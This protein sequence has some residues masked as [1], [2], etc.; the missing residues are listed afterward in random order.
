MEQPWDGI[1][2]WAE[3]FGFLQTLLYVEGEQFPAP[4]APVF[5]LPK[6]PALGSQP[7]ETPQIQHWNQ[8]QLR[9]SPAPSGIH[10]CP[11]QRLE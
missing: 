10:P 11:W 8:F 9:H 1:H 2:W 4:S 5:P 3:K 7:S 6:A